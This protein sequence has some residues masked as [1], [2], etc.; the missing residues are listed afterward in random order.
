MEGVWILVYKIG[1]VIR[2]VYVGEWYK[3][4]YVINGFFG[5][6][7]EFVLERGKD[8]IVVRMF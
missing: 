3:V 1:D 8:G 2:T 6:W 5:C 7:N 4:I